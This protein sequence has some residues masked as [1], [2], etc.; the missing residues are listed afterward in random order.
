M[1]RDVEYF[2]NRI[3][4]LAGAG[5]PG[6]YLVNL[7]KGKSVPKPKANPLPPPASNETTKQDTTPNGKTSSENT[8]PESSNGTSPE[9]AESK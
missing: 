7:V 5:D 9:Q 2:K 6:D 4:G 1:L 8:K 3:G